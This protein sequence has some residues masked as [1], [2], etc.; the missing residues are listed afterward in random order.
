MVLDKCHKSSWAN[1]QDVR[2]QGLFPGKA[3]PYCFHVLPLMLSEAQKSQFPCRPLKKFP[4]STQGT[5]NPMVFEMEHH[6]HHMIEAELDSENL[7]LKLGCH[8]PA[9]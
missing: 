2:S 1:P 9:K 8:L 3:D 4:V 5:S 7:G 6:G